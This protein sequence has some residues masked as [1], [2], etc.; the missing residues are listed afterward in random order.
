MDSIPLGLL[1]LALIICLAFSAFFSA[2]ETAMMSLNRYKLKHLA[3]EGNKRAKC[4][5]HLL[6]HTDRLIGTILLGN[7][8]VNIAATSLG[9]LIGLRLYGDLGV[10]LSTIILTVVVLVF[11]EV[12]PKTLAATNA[13]RIALPVAPVLAWLVRI[14]S[15]LVRLLNAIV[16]LILRP[17]GIKTENAVE[18]A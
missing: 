6:K 8:F 18:E 3:D 7:N 12:A 13:Q 1:I 9:T 4:A 14:F 10:L 5:S 2:S 15:P 11:S 17:L 16:R